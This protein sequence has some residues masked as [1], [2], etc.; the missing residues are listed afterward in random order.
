MKTKIKNYLYEN[1]IENYSLIGSASQFIY[2]IVFITILNLIFIFSHQDIL[3]NNDSVL[4]IFTFFIVVILLIERFDIHLSKFYGLGS[5]GSYIYAFYFVI[6]L[7]IF[8][9]S[10]IFLIPNILLNICLLF[11]F[12]P[13]LIKLL[14][15]LKNKL[16]EKGE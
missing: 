14:I 4:Q 13:K 3:I 7:L 11:L 15:N 2:T 9:G 10:K 5:F 16:Q 12:M 1:L 8:R 6:Q